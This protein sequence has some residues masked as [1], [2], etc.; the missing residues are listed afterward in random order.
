[1]HYS[2]GS[3]EGISYRDPEPVSFVNHLGAFDLIDG[4]LSIVPAEHFPDE[5]EARRAIE[6]FLRAW[7]KINGVR[8]D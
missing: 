2:A 3:G 1:M 6:P 4:K 5:E 7:V 8:L